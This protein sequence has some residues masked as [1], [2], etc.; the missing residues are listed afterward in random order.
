VAMSYVIAVFMAERN[1]FRA[2]LFDLNGK[3]DRLC[4]NAL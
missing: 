4:F 3:R 2:G 1:H